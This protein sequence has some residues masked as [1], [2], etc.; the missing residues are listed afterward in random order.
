MEASIFHALVAL[1]FIVIKECFSEYRNI[2]AFGLRTHL[3]GFV[4]L[5]WPCSMQI[6]NPCIL[7]YFKYWT[8][9]STETFTG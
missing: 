6:Y 7:A 3:R 9:G 8:I 5:R 4:C 2:E 1:T